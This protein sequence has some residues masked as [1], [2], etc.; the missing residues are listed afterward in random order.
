MKKHEAVLIL[1]TQLFEDHPLLKNKKEKIFLVEFERYFSD[2]TF[3]KQK[4]ILH[5]AT[6]Q[7]YKDH[8]KKKG[9]NVIYIN[10]KNINEFQKKLLEHEIKILRCCDTVDIPFEKELK[11]RCKQSNVSLKISDTPLFLTSSAWIKKYFKN[12]KH[13]RQQGFYQAQR[14]RLNVLMT[15]KGTPV[16]GKWSFDA[17]NRKPLP[18]SIKIPKF[19]KPRTNKYQKEALEYVEKYFNKNY[20]N[21]KTFFYPTTYST[22]KK[23]FDDFLTK[24][25][26]KFG[27]YQDAI[28]QKELILFHSILSPML[29][30]GLLTPEFVLKKTLIFAKKNNIPV[31][32]TEGF[33]RQLIGWRE[34]VRAVYILAGQEQRKSNFFEHTRKMPESFWDAKTTIAPVDDAI[35]QALNYAYNH[36]ILRLMVLGNFMLLCEINPDDIYRWFMEFFIDSYDWVMVPNVYGMSQY[37]DGGSM[38]TKPYISGSNYILKMSNYKKETWCETWDALYWRFI[39]KKRNIIKKIPRLAIMYSYLRRIPTKKIQAYIKKSDE[40]LAHL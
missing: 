9:H 19:Y 17:E 4:I 22:A 28:V 24:R 3:H 35:N 6:M 23:A 10:H 37:A 5:R 39:Y 20:G 36:H 21:P 30:I 26:A 27:P 25:F 15:Q 16:G 18:D 11:K 29:N 14:K 38:T 40:F 8:L 1:P 32:S 7:M 13:F 2:F 31:S 33:I 34:Y 12:K